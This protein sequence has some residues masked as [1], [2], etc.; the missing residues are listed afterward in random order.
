MGDRLSRKAY[1]SITGA[2][3]NI[4]GTDADAGADADA[5]P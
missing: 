2:S 3:S 4:L 5:E 1:G